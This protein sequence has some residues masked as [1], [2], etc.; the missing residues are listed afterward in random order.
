MTRRLCVQMH[1]VLYFFLLLFELAEAAHKSTS[2]TTGN[3]HRPTTDVFDADDDDDLS[4]F[5]DGDEDD[6]LSDFI[7]HEG[8]EEVIAPRLTTPESALSPKDD[9]WQDWYQDEETKPASPAAATKA[10]QTK[11]HQPTPAPADEPLLEPIQSGEALKQA[12]AVREKTVAALKAAN[13]ALRVKKLAADNT[14]KAAAV[15]AKDLDKA[16]AEEHR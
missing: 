16:K 14:A 11:K 12:T 1:R 6:D 7:E 15:A 8:A 5:V 13:L 10:K 4:S 3:L 9:A 2:D